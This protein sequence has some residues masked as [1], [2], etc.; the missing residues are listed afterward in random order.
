MV[1][2]LPPTVFVKKPQNVTVFLNDS[3]TVNFTCVTIASSTT[4]IAYYR[5]GTV[6]H[7]N[8]PGD[9]H[10]YNGGGGQLTVN[11]VIIV[12][13]AAY[14]DTVIHCEA[15]SEDG[16]GDMGTAKGHLLIQ[17]D[18]WLFILLTLGYGEWIIL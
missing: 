16:S 10:Y 6:I 12:T 1:C 7:E 13:K 8:E 3:G 4:L 5:N 11:G 15:T 17:G 18:Y 9:L 14:N 2:F